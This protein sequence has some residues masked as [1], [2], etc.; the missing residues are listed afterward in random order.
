MAMPA[1]PEDGPKI[2][3][4]D[5]TNHAGVRKV[6]E[7]LPFEFHFMSNEWHPQQQWLLEAFDYERDDVR[8]FAV[9]GIHRWGKPSDRREM[10]VDLLLTKQLQESIQKNSRMTSRLKSLQNRINDHQPAHE[11]YDA[12]SAIDAI[13]HDKDPT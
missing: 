1:A 8:Y 5:Y 4:I 7:I 3:L 13:L 12:A 10:G 2:V 6:R 9:S 11:T